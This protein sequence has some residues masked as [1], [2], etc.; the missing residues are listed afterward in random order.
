MGKEKGKLLDRRYRLEERI[1][2]GG[3]GAVYRAFDTRIGRIVALKELRQEY[4][5]DEMIRKR[6]IREAQAAGQLKHPHVVTVHD[7]FDEDSDLYIVMEYLDGGTLLDRMNEAPG[8]CVNLWT[9]LKACREALEGLSAAHDLSLVHRDVK[10]GNLLFDSDGTVKIADFG[11]VTAL[12]RE[13]EIT[14]LTQV[15]T[16]PGTLVYMSPEQIDGAEVDGRSDVYSMAAVLYE[17]IAGVRYFERAG[18]RRTER[19][20]MDAICEVPPVPIRQ[21]APHVPREVEQIL[22]HA[23]T[24]LIEDRPSARQMAAALAEIEAKRE[25]LDVADPGEVATRPRVASTGPRIEL[26]AASSSESSAETLPRARVTPSEEATVPRVVKPVSDPT[27]LRDAPARGPETRAAKAS[28][29]ERPALPG[30]PPTLDRAEAPTQARARS[31]ERTRAR[32]GAVEVELPGG[33]AVIGGGQSS[34]ELPR[35]RVSVSG[36]AIDRAPVTVR[37]YRAFLE[38]VSRG[39]SLDVPL[40]AALYPNGKD[41][42]PQG[43]G[44]IEFEMLCPTDEHP[45]VNVDWFD[46]CA[47]AAWVGARLPS[48]VEWE[49]AARGLGGER[50]YPWG[51]LQPSLERAHFGR[52]SQGPSPVGQL[53]AGATPEGL[54]D[55]AGNVWEW[56]RDAYDPDGYAEHEE[57]D[58]CLPIRGPSARAVKRGASWTN[59]PHSLRCSKRGFEKLHIRRNNLG[60]R[61]ARD[62]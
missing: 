22:E 30:R 54:L 27:T 49:R 34:D 19:A 31:P 11:V 35:R 8:R 10:P 56:C 52:S 57:R 29:A 12:E 3:M 23:L 40:L 43:W 39:V 50:I 42:R 16:H 38:A 61:C 41:H 5:E 55:M 62:E 37:Q 36:F 33:V 17:A 44:S 25:E 15:G 6:F 59:A 45:I 13:G 53:P 21:H 7:Y 47:Y 4:S 60:F 24:K 14:T 58:P 1:G 26:A 18:M 46:A 48:E 32:D 51:D 9:A 28:S 2:F 20:L